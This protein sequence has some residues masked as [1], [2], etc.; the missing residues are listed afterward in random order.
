MTA[1][2]INRWEPIIMAGIGAAV[3]QIDPSLDT[4]TMLIY[5][6]K[7]FIGAVV[8][9]YFGNHMSSYRQK[10]EEKEKEGQ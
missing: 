1:L 6:I 5:A 8:G 7:A 3:I 10:K 9:A 2:S 4:R